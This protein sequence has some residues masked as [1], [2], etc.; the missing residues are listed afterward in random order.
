MSQPRFALAWLL[1]ALACSPACYGVEPAIDLAAD[2]SPLP[3]VVVEADLRYE[4]TATAEGSDY[5]TRSGGSVRL[6]Y[7]QSLV[8]TPDGE[9]YVRVVDACETP[10]ASQALRA[11][12]RVLI[13]QP[14]D[15]GA[16]VAAADGPLQRGELD[17]VQHS[18]DPLDLAW[19]TPDRSLRNGGTW[20]VD[21]IALGRLMR[22]ESIS[23]A[24]VTGVVAE[25]NDHFV[26]LRLA[27]PLHGVVDGARVEIDLRGAALLNRDTRR[28]DRIH[29]AW[30]EKRAVGPATPALEAR[31]KLN[32]S[33]RPATS[34]DEPIS[35]DTLARAAATPLDTRLLVTTGDGRWSLLAERDWFVVARG[36]EAT[37]LRRI[38]GDQIAA[39]TTLT[40]QTKLQATAD[41]L[42]AEVRSALGDRLQQ[43]ASTNRGRSAAGLTFVEVAALGE[44]EGRPAVWMRTHVAAED[45][46]LAIAATIASQDAQADG[47]RVRRLVES[48]HRTRQGAADIA[49]QPSA[50]RR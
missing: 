29:L 25:A 18:A 46:A 20:K 31:A 2:L 16:R 47:D 23:L 39:V 26:L 28:I 12:R 40:P 15:A 33:V 37:T 9:R 30:D 34:R 10:G 8:D 21:L 11:D 19:L 1:C 48:L 42:R 49:S 45:Q 38:D 6:K 44:V 41:D 32:V 43:F 7:R 35:A 5:P 14:G 24:E 27:G 36:A 17:L 4:A 50:A 3:A 22:V 13:A